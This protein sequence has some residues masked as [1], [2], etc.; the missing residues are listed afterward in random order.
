MIAAST[1]VGETKEVQSPLNVHPFQGPPE[2]SWDRDAH[3]G[4][5]AHQ[6][7]KLA[8]LIH[9]GKASCTLESQ[10][11]DLEFDSNINWLYKLFTLFKPHSLY[12]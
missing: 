3:S 11:L 9:W 8:L 2:A 5:V 6:W 12:Q 7:G 1:V 4:S 10:D